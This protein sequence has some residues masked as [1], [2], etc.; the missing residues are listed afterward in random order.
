MFISAGSHISH[1]G[2]FLACSCMALVVVDLTSM[3]LFPKDHYT[4]FKLTFSFEVTL[5]IT[6]L[7][8]SMFYVSRLSEA[9]IEACQHSMEHPAVYHLCA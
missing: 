8:G 5:A 1:V 3:C 6:A 7:S 2:L 4:L 9:L